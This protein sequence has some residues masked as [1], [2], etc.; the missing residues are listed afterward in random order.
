MKMAKP[1]KPTKLR[2]Q[3]TTQQAAAHCQV[4]V[5]T[6][7]R[8]IKMGT[9]RAVR[10][11]GGHHRV[12]IEEFERFLR[13]Q[14]MPPYSRPPL[15]EAR[16]LIVDDDRGVVDLLIE[17]LANDPR[18]LKLE[19]ATDGFEALVKAGFFR[20]ALLILDISMPGMDGIEV[21]RR[22]KAQPETRAIRILGI[23]GH[24]ERVSALM[25]AG[26]DGCLAKPLSLAT[27]QNEV[28]R[29]LS[30]QRP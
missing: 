17:V 6:L 9:L 13:E 8:W 18:A 5:S 14:G 29:L 30:E 4:A 27:F 20:P 24:Q 23:T 10:T 22:L 28:E 2:R 12:E 25:E 16:I 1:T 21:C 11:P 3:V 7:K 26:A 15:E 19:A